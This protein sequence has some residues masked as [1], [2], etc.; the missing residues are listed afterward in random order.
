MAL[1]PPR[2]L[3]AALA[4]LTQ[5]PTV[6]QSQRYETLYSFKGTPDG[7]DP[8][9]ALLIG[10]SGE[11]YGTTFAGG[12]SVLGT[13][14]VL[15]PAAGQPWNETILH[16]F[17]GS[18]GQYPQ[19]ALTHGS[20][21]EFYGVTVGGGPG[22]SGA[23]F[24]LAPP[25]TSGEAWTETVLYSFVYFTGNGQN[26]VPNGPV[27]IG[28]GGTLYT[29]TQGGPNG[30]TG[31]PLGLVVA[32]EP[33]AIA[34]GAWAEYELYA[35]GFPQGDLPLASVASE[36][37]SLLGTTFYGGD[38]FCGE[39]GC[40]TVYELTPPTNRSG[41]WTETTIHTFAG[42]PADGGG[43][44]GNL[45]AGPGGVLYG[46]TQ[47]GGS[48]SPSTCVFANG[49]GCGTVFELTPPATPGG[50]WTAS[51]LYSFT[52]TSGDGAYPEAGV[53][54]G[55]NGALYGTTTNGG[56]V[57]S[58]CP[59]SFFSIG[60]CGTVFELTPPSAPGGAWTETVLHSFSG[61]N[62]DGAIPMAGLVQSPTGV[63][64]GTTT[65]GGTAGRGTVFAVAP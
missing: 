39:G 24:E 19:S 50:T 20:N 18:D 44:I 33:P 22:G 8:K 35:F 48:G 64:Y 41:V 15:A 29:T 42:A 59:P 61:Q 28:P 52:G 62:G 53:V 11:L 37:G 6:A 17:T 46:T 5:H 27:L 30:P 56:A 43:A 40:G 1:S 3:L 26:A 63:L 36:G 34:G 13:V 38:E 12:T 4:I 45:I 47:Y 7:A 57:S 49:S 2:V 31:F 21:G 25:T 10:R 54:L 51:V 14:F 32:L 65:A 9:G 55:K 58:A 16:N 23:I 60:G